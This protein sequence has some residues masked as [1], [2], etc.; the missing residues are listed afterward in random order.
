MAE[1]RETQQNLETN[2][3]Q[4]DASDTKPSICEFTGIH[5]DVPEFPKD[6]F[7]VLQPTTFGLAQEST[8]PW[9]IGNTFID[10]LNSAEIDATLLKV[11]PLKFSVSARTFLEGK[12]V[13]VK[14]R[15]YKDDGVYLLELQQNTGCPVI[16]NKVYRKL[17]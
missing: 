5:T 10:F 3:L 8:E 15:I 6:A 17:L 9:R 12:M 11:S 16:F 4:L 1:V 13:R 2:E 14:A 7:L